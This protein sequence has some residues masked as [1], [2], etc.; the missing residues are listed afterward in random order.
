MYV[1]VVSCLPCGDVEDCKEEEVVNKTLSLVE[2]T[3]HQEDSETCSPFCICA[4]CGTNIL[5]S[6][7]FHTFISE[8]R[9]SLL[10]QKTNIRYNNDSLFSNFYGNIWQPPQI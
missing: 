1:L 3:D 9:P 2:H 8:K 7:T 10:S 6:F 4:C 5:S